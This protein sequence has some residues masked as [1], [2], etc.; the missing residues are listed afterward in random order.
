MPSDILLALLRSALTG[1]EPECSCS[2]DEWA[3]VYAFAVKQCV[4]GLAY[5]GVSR[6]PAS[7]CPPRAILMRWARNAEAIKGHNQLLNDI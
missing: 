5:Q 1:V 3:E 6:L 7:K 4:V 2:P